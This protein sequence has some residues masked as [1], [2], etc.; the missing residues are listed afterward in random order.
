MAFAHEWTPRGWLQL[1]GELAQFEQHLYLSQPGYGTSYL[2]G[3]SEIQKL[4]AERGKQLGDDFT[5]RGFLDDLFNSGV[6]PLSLVRWELT[7]K[8]D[9]ID[10]IV[11]GYRPLG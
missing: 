2:L 8:S 11:A 9:E 7:G 5:V 6:V 1:G 4:M 3:K 10:A